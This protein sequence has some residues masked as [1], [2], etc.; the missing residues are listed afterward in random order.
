MF[1]VLFSSMQDMEDQM[2]AKVIDSKD[3]MYTINNIFA[4]LDPVKCGMFMPK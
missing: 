1:S 3:L 2:H 4:R